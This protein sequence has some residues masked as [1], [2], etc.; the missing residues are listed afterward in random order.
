MFASFDYELLRFNVILFTAPFNFN[1]K[2][3][4]N[5]SIFKFKNKILDYHQL[6]NIQI[7]VLTEAE[8]VIIDQF[9][10]SQ[11]LQIDKNLSRLILCPNFDVNEFPCIFG[12]NFEVIDISQ[13]GIHGALQ[14]SDKVIGHFNDNVKQ[15]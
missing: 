2:V 5:D 10:G 6:D 14:V 15:Q 8:V 7:C 4:P 9:T 13:S 3:L 12:D 1:Y 11:I